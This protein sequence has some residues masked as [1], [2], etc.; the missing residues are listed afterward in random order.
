MRLIY[1]FWLRILDFFSASIC[2]RYSDGKWLTRPW[3]VLD[4]CWT[5]ERDFVSFG[6]WHLWVRE[7]CCRLCVCGVLLTRLPIHDDSY[8]KARSC[9]ECAHLCVEIRHT[10][11]LTRRLVGVPT[12]PNNCLISKTIFTW[13]H[14]SVCVCAGALAR[15]TKCWWRWWWYLLNAQFI[16]CTLRCA[17]IK[18]KNI[19]DAL[20]VVARS[21]QSKSQQ[22]AEWRSTACTVHSNR[23]KALNNL[24]SLEIWLQRL[25]KMH[26]FCECVS[27][28]TLQNVCINRAI[29]KA[30]NDV[31]RGEVSI[32]ARRRSIRNQWI[33]TANCVR[34]C[35]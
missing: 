19:D 25:I 15:C 6:L 29:A 1:W 12:H 8:R 3:P 16:C 9:R 28:W 32:H 33:P 7:K 34:E 11:S 18:T 20:A 13:L 17:A 4:V 10:H 24:L 31:L 5:H 23:P 35:R 30:T 21:Q 22:C 14:W 27:F 2:L 26:D